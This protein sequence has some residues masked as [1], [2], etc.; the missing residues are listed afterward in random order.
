MVPMM[1]LQ[2]YQVFPD[3]PKSLSFLEKLSQNLWWSWNLDAIELFRRI[4]PRLWEV[5]GH[6]P[7][8]FSTLL[9]KERLESLAADDS[10]LA[11]LERVKE[12]F[13]ANFDQP[14][15]P[16][17]SP[18][19]PKDVIAY[20]SMEFGLHE[21]L[22]IFAGGLGILS[23]DHLKA[24]SDTAVPLVAVGLLY[25]R[26]YFHQFL[27]P[28][29][30]Q[31]EEYPETDLYHL[32]IR[33]AKDAAGHLVQVSVPGPEGPMQAVVWKSFVGRVPLYLLDTN[34]PENP[35]EIRE[36]TSRLYAG[37]P[38]LRLAQEIL[39]G[40]GGM[41]ALAAMG[42]ESCVCHMNEGHCAFAGLERL[43]Q[44]MASHKLD[45]QTA[46]EIV[47]RS[48]VFTTHTPVAA[49]HDE[50][51]VD[52][53]TPYLNPYAEI[54]GMPVDEILSWG[55]PPDAGSDSPVSMFI[56]AIHLAQFCNG[57][58]EL[59]GSVARRMWSHVWPKL[60]DE[61][62]PITHITNGVHIP[63][64]ISIENSLLFERYLGPDWH[65]CWTA[66]CG[67]RIDEIYDEELWRAHEMA[68]S[69][70]IRF[71]RSQLVKQHG[72]RNAPKAVMEEAESVLDQEVLTI[73]FARRFATYKRANLLL[74]DPDRL[75]AM[76][77]SET[78]PVQ[79]I[80]AGKAHPKDNEGK[81]LIQKL[82]EFCRNPAIR[83]RVVFIEDYEINVARHLIQGADIWLN[84]P[85]RPFEACGTSGMKAAANGVLN[86]SIMDGWW[87]EGYA[88]D[89]GWRIGNGEVYDDPH[90]QD[91]VESQ[92]LYNILENDIIPC[93]YERR[94]GDAPARWIGMMKA[95]MKMAMQQFCAHGMVKKYE[96]EFYLKAAQQYRLLLE[97]HAEEA[98]R[99]KKQRQRLKKRWKQI[100]IDPPVRNGDGPFRVGNTFHVTAQVEL[101]ELRP[102]EVDIELY[103]G[104][105]K[106]LDTLKE[107]HTAVMS[108]EEDRG[109]GTYVYGCD[110]TCENSGRFGFT[111]RATPR[112]DDRLKFSPGFFTWSE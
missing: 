92:A 87:C 52:M 28:S 80:F 88:E 49:G 15:N 23:G 37:E 17:E 62:V 102:D 58:S 4:D 77:T 32:P 79:L 26:G 8:L 89:R 19:D 1:R 105:F 90:Y 20:F 59:H 35:P 68:R 100:R 96:S 33:R 16:A 18:Y 54:F 12:N 82:V 53:V 95:S 112:G 9:S 78:R 103:Y 5:S 63:S 71:S 51:P 107:S 60:P 70:L 56:L 109:N 42:I 47:P 74:Q 45:L 31:Q 83:H 104:L 39:L 41:R 65:L 30:W 91:A 22:P 106:T 111:A 29:G 43:A 57:V 97:N 93:F 108:V 99:Q 61:E 94:N 73:G 38:K 66:D 25:R 27:D 72:R 76:L 48:T 6:N 110:I 10:Y 84:T 46:F 55:Q 86:V 81:A 7:I 24:A 21:S 101:G 44:T 85:R 13:T 11:H 14:D 98:R 2:T 69:R 75:E 36:V 67:S 64:Y 34:I 3:T 50:F 40:I